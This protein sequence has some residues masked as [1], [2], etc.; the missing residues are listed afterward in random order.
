MNMC[1]EWWSKVNEKLE[2]EFIALIPTRNKHKL[3]KGLSHPLGAEYISTALQ[4]VPQYS[5]LQL[6]F[7][8]NSF[9]SKIDY[10]Y[11]VDQLG[12]IE[13]IEISYHP[14]LRG[15]AAPD[16]NQED[17]TIWIKP[18]PSDRRKIAKKQ[19]IEIGL[20]QAKEWLI[21][22]DN[23]QIAQNQRQEFKIYYS[24]SEDKIFSKV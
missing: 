3:P 15:P 8:D 1:L 6:V 11:A 19:L 21:S 14:K 4:G 23:T 12:D 17:W 10:Q 13:I 7:W 24:L 16:V 22:I 2:N 9:P 5:L 20:P 18:I